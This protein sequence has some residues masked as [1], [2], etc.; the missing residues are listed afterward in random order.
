MAGEAGRCYTGMTPDEIAGVRPGLLDFTAEMLGRAG[1]AR[2]SGRPGSCTC[3]G[4]WRT[5][6]ASR[7][8]RWR[9]G[10]GS[11]ISGC[12]SSSRPRP[13]I[14]PPCGGTW[15]GG[16]PPASRWRRSWSM[17]PAFPR[18]RNASPCVGPA[19]FRDAAARRANC[20]VAVSVHLVNEGASCAADWRLF[21][22]QS[23]DDQALADPVAA[24][25]AQRRRERRRHPRDRCATGRSWRLA[26]DM[27][28]EMTVT[29]AGGA[30]WT[31][32]RH[33]RC[34]PGGGR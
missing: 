18:T 12:S 9:G 27:I 15:R 14:T 21:C 5:G 3:G 7:W 28:E 31:W 11:I 33:R 30:S 19:V 6:S 26:L 4:C 2:T 34:P 23:W 32:P 25:A 16:S 24:A 10:W 17:T 20:Q 1:S 8:C 29:S 22:P 13:G